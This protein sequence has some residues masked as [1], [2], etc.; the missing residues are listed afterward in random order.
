MFYLGTHAAAYFT[1]YICHN[2]LY[3]KIY[4][5]KNM[6]GKDRCTILY[7]DVMIETLSS[8]FFSGQKR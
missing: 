5:F 7:V 1:Y 8:R 3:V 4:L 6:L 2:L